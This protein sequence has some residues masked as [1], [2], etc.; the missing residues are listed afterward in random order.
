MDSEGGIE[1]E[2]DERMKTL[3]VGNVLQKRI[4]AAKMLISTAIRKK[5]P[6]AVK[7]VTA[8]VYEENNRFP[9][10]DSPESDPQMQRAKA[11]FKTRWNLDKLF[12]SNDIILPSDSPTL[13][14]L[15][16]HK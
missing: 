13:R 6:P 12:A 14:L 15:Y 7:Q 10:K 3:H 1:S 2:L 9:L 8:E 4:V 5:S 11:S 16:G